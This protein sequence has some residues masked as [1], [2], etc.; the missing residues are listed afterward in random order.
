MQARLD[1][2][3]FS[4]LQIDPTAPCSLLSNVAVNKSTS[5]LPLAP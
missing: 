2:L 3:S 5:N 4:I 1:R